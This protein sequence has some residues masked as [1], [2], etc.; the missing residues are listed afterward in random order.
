M[1]KKKTVIH[2]FLFWGLFLLFVVFSIGGIALIYVSLDLPQIE[3]FS[4]R[5]VPQTTKI[6]DKTGEILLYDLYGDQKRTTIPLKEVPLS[7]QHA[8][9]ALEDKDFYN[10]S[11]F[12]IKSIVRSFIVN[13][14]EGE[15]L[16]GGSTI[17][18]QLV[19]NALL[20]PQK[21][22]S[23]KVKELILA[24]KLEQQYSKNQILEL[25]L[26]EIPYGGNAYGIEA[27]GQSYFDKS[28]KD[29]TLAEAAI[30]AALPKAPTFYS[31]YG[32]N[33]KIY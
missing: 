19:K 6:Y 17:T 11:A 4:D 3:N 31:P 33:T 27:A 20:D 25:Y 22:I 10:H 30:L 2:S 12:S 18:Q 26:N 21:T 29:L 13:I 14:R 28:T 24:Y 8:T 16:Q 7:V 5:P 9:L 23:R 1:K 32:S 15:T